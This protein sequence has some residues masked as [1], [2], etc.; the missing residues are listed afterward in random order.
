[1]E[2]SPILLEE[3]NDIEVLQDKKERRNISESKEKKFIT[4]SSGHRS[5]LKDQNY[6]ML[7]SL[8]SNIMPSKHYVMNSKISF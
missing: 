4:S 6:R 2:P 7:M 5:T 8:M 3:D 1:M